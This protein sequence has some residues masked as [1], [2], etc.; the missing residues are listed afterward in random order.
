MLIVRALVTVRVELGMSG[1]LIEFDVLVERAPVEDV[2]QLCTST[3]RQDRHLEST[4]FAKQ[5]ELPFVA[6]RFDR[7]EILIG[8]MSV[9]IGFNVR[10]P[11]EDQPVESS[12]NA[13]H[14]GVARQFNR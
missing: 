11:T 6:V 9:A 3:D 10:S 4:G 5:C 2:G 14:V 8:V 13:L 1:T 12:E 7:P